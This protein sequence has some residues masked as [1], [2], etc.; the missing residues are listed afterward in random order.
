MKLFLKIILL[1]CF[2][3]TSFEVN[4]QQ[5]T[6][7]ITVTDDPSSSLINTINN[8]DDFARDEVHLLPTGS[9]GE[10]HL[11]PQSS[12]DEVHLHID[13]TIILPV[14]YQSSNG[15]STTNPVITKTIDMTLPVGSTSG[16][17]NVN[18]YGGLNYS[19][20]IDLPPGTNKIIPSLSINY[21]SY[22]ANDIL[23]F[24][25]GISGVSSIGRT[26]QNLFYSNNV[27]PINLDNNDLFN[28]DGSV[29][30]PTSGLNGQD[31]SIYGTES[32]SFMRITSHGTTGSGPSWFN[33]E[34]KEGITMEY[35]NT[36][37][38][39]FIPKGQST[40]LKWMINKMY[41]NYGNYV[42]FSYHNKD[43][44]IYIEKILYTGN[45]VANITPFN[46]IN[47]YYDQRQDKNTSFIA[48]GEIDETVIL[49]RIEVTSENIQVKSFD[50]NYSYNNYQSFLNEIIESGSTSDH[51]NSMQFSYQDDLS[52]SPISVASTMTNNNLFYKYQPVDM[53][54]DGKADLVRFGGSFITGTGSGSTIGSGQLYG[55]SSLSLGSLYIPSSQFNWL[56]WDILKN[57]SSSSFSTV[58]SNSSFPSNL[59]LFNDFYPIS[60]GAVGNMLLESTDL[61]GDGKE[62]ILITGVSEGSITANGFSLTEFDIYPCLAKD[63]FAIPSTPIVAYGDPNPKNVS[64]NIRFMDINGDQKLDIFNIYHDPGYSPV[65]SNQGTYNDIM[66]VWLDVTNPT[67]TI[68]TSLPATSNTALYGTDSPL[69]YPYDFSSAVNADIDGDGKTELVNVF[70]GPHS[71]QFIVKYV[72]SNIVFQQDNSGYTYFPQGYSTDE[73]VPI[74][75]P[76]PSQDHLNFY[77]DFNGDLITDVLKCIKNQSGNNWTEDFGQGDGSY[78][79]VALSSTMP[80]PYSCS[81]LIMIKDLNSDGKSDIL[82]LVFNNTTSGPSYGATYQNGMNIYYSLGTEFIKETQTITT[83]NSLSKQAVD[84]DFADFNGD[85]SLDLITSYPNSGF[86]IN[87]DIIYFYKGVKS[88]YLYEVVDGFNIANKFSFDPLSFP[89]NS[90][91]YTQNSSNAKTYPLLNFNGPLYA[92][93]NITI[94]DGIGGNNV[95]SYAYQDAIIHK[96]GKGFIGFLTV[97]SYNST[98]F[99][100]NIKKYDFNSTYFNLYT[101]S[102][103]S[104]LLT[105]SALAPTITP[106]STEVYTNNTTAL[107]SGR[108]YT[109]IN[110]VLFNDLISGKTASTDL[111]YDNYGNLLTRTVNT[112]SNYDVEQETNTYTQM[113]AW[114][115]SR[116]AS[117]AITTTRGGNT[118]SR[119]STYNY[120]ATD[121]GQL[122]SILDDK[123]LNTEFQY[124]GNTGV[125]VKKLIYASTVPLRKTEYTY[126]ANFRYPVSITNPLNQVS[127]YTY[128]GRWGKILTYQGVDGLTTTYTF[129]SFGRLIGSKSP[130]NITSTTSYNWVPNGSMPGN[131]PIDVSD[132]SY[133]ITKQVT[134]RPTE[135]KYYNTLGM[136]RKE[137]TDGFSDKIYKVIGYDNKSNVT[138]AS[139]PYQTTS[140]ALTPV[141]TTTTYDALNRIIKQEQ[142]DNIIQTP[143]LT[144]YQYAYSNGNTT[145]TTVLPDGMT[146]SKT[147]DPTGLVIG[148]TD[149]GG[150]VTFDY[151]GNRKMK[152][153]SV[154]GYQMM[155]ASYDNFGRR[156]SLTDGNSGTMQYTYDELDELIT[157]KDALNNTY[158]LTYDVMGRVTQ[159]IG[160]GEGT[161]SY[162]YNT[163]GNG[164]NKLQQSVSPTG[165]TNNY[166]Y[167]ALNRIHKID[168]T[169][170]GN[171]FTTQYEYDVYNNLSKISSPSS[172][173]F[174]VMREYTS[175]GYLNKVSDNNGQLIWQADEMNGLNQYTKYTLGNNVQTQKLYSNFGSPISYMASGTQNLQF[176]VDER[177]GN[178]NSR[179]DALLGLSEAFTY[180]NLNRLTGSSVTTPNVSYPAQSTSYSQ[181]GNITQKSDAGTYTYSSIKPNAVETVSNPNAN[182]SLTEQDIS[183]TAFNKV[184]S[185]TEGDYQLNVLYGSDQQRA[186]TDL[187][188]QSSLQG[189]K[190]F[191]GNYEKQVSTGEIQEINYIDGGDGL[192]A[193]YVID[194]GVGTMY[195]AYTDNLGSILTLK[196]QNG[197]KYAQNF[198]AYGR[199]RSPSDWSYSNIP[200]IP[201]W[202][203]RGFTGHE[204]LPEFSLVNMNGRMYDPLIGMMLTPDKV[205]ADNT[206]TQGYNS[207]NYA[208]NR[209][210]VYVDKSGDCPICVILVIA[211]IAAVINVEENTGPGASTEQVVDAFVTG[212][213]AGAFAATIGVVAAPVGIGAGILTGIGSSLTS[214]TILSYGNHATLG[215]PLA[216]PQQYLTSVAVGGLLGGAAGGIAAKLAPVPTNIVTGEPIVEVLDP[217]ISIKTFEPE[218]VGSQEITVSEP[219]IQSAEPAT[220]QEGTTWNVETKPNI[221]QDVK[222][223]D[224]NNNV[225]VVGDR[226]NIKINGYIDDIDAKPG[227]YHKFPD[228]LDN[229]IIQGGAWAQRLKDG[230]NW[231]EAPGSWSYLDG[232]GNVKTVYGNYEIGINENGIIF[233]KLFKPW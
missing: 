142:T 49:R 196:D 191:V 56:G 221:S 80:D 37:D 133:Q 65:N 60:S 226:S 137:E 193:I 57:N 159:K 166:T 209:P 82:E 138:I 170:N 183:Y 143:L 135:K 158:T 78:K 192:A 30:L 204:H 210:T 208:L 105:F 185:I 156:L 67:P 205:V 201:N 43:G 154:N 3:F 35:G 153:T 8:Q 164:I 73:C 203:Y 19:I 171:V 160:T 97:T 173:N 42:L 113:D 54:G 23:G 70:D 90:T 69:D 168:K 58:V 162:Q 229:E 184:Q 195:Y 5:N 163:S 10:V 222:A 28:I 39:K 122:S 169:I 81:N 107:N 103:S 128:D 141:L 117:S 126:D 94:P 216:T 110:N 167:D 68:L 147:T 64:Q 233:H 53:D 108:F 178:L 174:G 145:I 88:K 47:F 66:R 61:D 25:W 9:G 32:E 101:S 211:I 152:T 79:S 48:T 114:I 22:G 198:D 45:T 131:D 96:N 118:S 220:I 77:G 207:Y 75:N 29:I 165:V 41:D 74:T 92:V 21:N 139:L 11:L 150:N 18:Q 59:Y 24:G 224:G 17:F 213:Y 194:N 7:T 115:P 109:V 106:I 121:N 218:L 124:D 31:G 33:V 71:Q 176:S 190:Y 36:T 2:G 44:E 157:Q 225:T 214:T 102:S 120:N 232:A 93:S 223:L 12:T 123:G 227:M 125:I 98:S 6:G 14:N 111:A 134:G 177:N 100:L 76:V 231:F 104:N 62:D 46:S 228:L 186:K 144:T 51:Y 140:N 91:F 84:Y 151:F 180:D 119:Q 99:I 15:S 189:T 200:T 50:F 206:S 132:I 197:N 112:N 146:S 55:P 187:F 40:A 34:T 95:T 26:P 172:N 217:S 38:S 199:N 52:A 63:D 87:P 129:D 182:I 127:N 212:F 136:V 4:A 155:S 16:S 72:N 149:N 116:L 219:A 188:Y 161:Y 175:A 130:D 215:T 202:L 13:P 179:S 230:A 89:T 85:G 27:A 83:K 1:I 148:S 86:N 20:P 181:N